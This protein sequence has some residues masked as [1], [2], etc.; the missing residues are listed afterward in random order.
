MPRI[1]RKT[2]G[3]KKAT[4]MR[5][6]TA[7]A[8]KAF[9]KKA[10]KGSQETKHNDSQRIEQNSNTVGIPYY[11]DDFMTMTYGSDGGQANYEGNKVTNVGLSIKWILNNNSAIGIFARVLVL[12]NRLGRTNTDYRNGTNIF[13]FDGNNQSTTGT[14]YDMHRMISREQYIVHFD[15]VYK[16]GS[17]SADAS[18]FLN[19]KFYLPMKGQTKYD[20][21]GGVT[22]TEPL[23]NNKVLLIIT[24]EGPNDT[25]LGVITECTSNGRYYYKDA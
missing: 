21:A 15:R 16:L 25:G 8:T 11:Q 10:I 24:A 18:N 17:S 6:R 1:N 3:P 4:V 9:V 20:I 23:L 12:T 13:D 19:G 2:A 22:T 14:L 5:K 7:L